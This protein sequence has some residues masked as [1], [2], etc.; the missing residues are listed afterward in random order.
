VN[1]C[2]DSRLPI[3]LHLC[4]YYEIETFTSGELQ[5]ECVAL[6][7]TGRGVFIGVRGGVIDLIKSVTCQV[8]AG[9]PWSLDSTDLQLG[10]PLYC[11]LEIITAKP[12]HER[13]Q[14]GASRP[15]TP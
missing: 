11:L 14:G 4:Y 13:L 9:W 10:N 8:V 15:A 6:I 3:G 2:L 7:S 12:T 1:A 5:V